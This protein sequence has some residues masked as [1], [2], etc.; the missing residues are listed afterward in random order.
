MNSF[1][2]KTCKLADPLICSSSNLTYLPFSLPILGL[3]NVGSFLKAGHLYALAF[4]HI[5]MVRKETKVLVRPALFASHYRSW[6][7]SS[8]NTLEHS[9]QRFPQNVQLEW[10]DRDSLSP[11]AQA[12]QRNN[13][14]L[15]EIKV[16]HWHRGISW[17]EKYKKTKQIMQNC[18]HVVHL[19][20][21]TIEMNQCGGMAAHSRVH[22][23]KY[24]VHN[25]RMFL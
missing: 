17:R 1:E 10:N 24:T 4:L 16:Y 8:Q 12:R 2:E 3:Q 21:P 15:V 11:E 13:E 7:T 6:S 20:E 19:N 9:G 22:Y 25:G 23:E 18:A 5:A 14:R